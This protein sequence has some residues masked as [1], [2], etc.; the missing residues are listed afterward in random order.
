MARKYELTIQEKYDDLD[1][2]IANLENAIDETDLEDYKEDLQQILF[3]AQDEFEQVEAEKDE[4]EAR[5]YE[6]E[7]KEREREYRSMV[8]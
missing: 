7:M 3:S 2:L 8:L 6:I 5:E 1:N 4:E